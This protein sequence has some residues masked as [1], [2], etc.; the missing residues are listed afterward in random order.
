M[1]TTKPTFR[2][3]EPDF[4]S[5]F[6][7]KHYKDSVKDRFPFWHFHPE[8]ELVYVNHGGGKRHIGNHIS[9]FKNSQLV[10][11]GS[12]LP[13]MG[14]TDR[15]T[16]N[17]TETIVQMKPDFLGEAF[18]N[19]P[20][21]DAIHK[22]FERAKMGLLFHPKIKKEVGPKITQL[23]RL[24]GIS[25]LLKF[26]EILHEL[27]ITEDYTMLNAQDFAVEVYQQDNDRVDQIFKYI[28]KNFQSHI[29]LEDIAEEVNMTPPSFCRYLKKVTGKT[30]TALVN[31][32]RIVHASKLLAE[33]P[34]SITD[35]CY[36]SGF[37]NFSHFNKLFKKKTGWSPSNYRN[38]MK[39]IIT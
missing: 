13:H 35:I 8:L 24:Q 21:T 2:K 4:G 34:T 18:I 31:E 9:Y 25:R 6:L 7:L 29:A 33:K 26:I 17:G 16:T 5:S 15:L 1:N 20:E 36:E 12:N 11:V 28:T 22:L 3:I 19:L 37:N 14:Y 30:F 39:R 38:E 32:Y 27:A 23:I 10:L